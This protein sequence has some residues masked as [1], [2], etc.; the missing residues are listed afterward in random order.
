MSSTEDVFIPIRHGNHIRYRDLHGFE[1]VEPVASILLV[2]NLDRGDCKIGRVD[3]SEDTYTH[4]LL[5]LL[6]N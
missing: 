6:D 1:Y 3:V 4:I 2:R 5:H